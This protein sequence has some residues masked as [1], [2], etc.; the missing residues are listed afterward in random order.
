M[1]DSENDTGFG[2]PRAFTFV[3]HTGKFWDQGWF[4]FR[5][6]IRQTSLGLRSFWSLRPERH[7]RRQT[8]VTGVAQLILSG[9]A[10]LSRSQALFFSLLILLPGNPVRSTE[11]E[12][13]FIPG[14][15]YL[16]GRSHDLPDDGLKWFPT[17]LKDERPARQ[18]LV[19]S[20]YID[21]HE[22]TNHQYAAFLASTGRDAPYYWSDGKPP[23]G[24]EDYPVVNVSWHE[25]VAYCR[26]SGKRLPTEAEWEHAARGVREGLRFPWG[27]EEPSRE[28]HARFDVIDGPGQVSRFPVNDFGLHDMAGNVWEWCSDWYGRE[29]YSQAPEQNPQG[30]ARGLY[31]TLRGGCWADEAKFLTCSYRSFARPVERS[32]TI[33]FRCAKDCTEEK[34][35]EHVSGE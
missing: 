29:Y 33:G 5:T 21:R 8:F 22:V 25:A 30:P 17:L 32:P 11:P 34:P 3:D 31:R 6:C 12:M 16:R 24:K 9:V 4:L 35:C 19:A 14:G 28:N 2:E 20:F 13:V 26:W 27:S 10:C 15:S 23:R 7:R 1:R 18:I